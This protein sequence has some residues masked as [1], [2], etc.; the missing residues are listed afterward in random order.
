MNICLLVINYNGLFFLNKYLEDISKVCSSS[1]IDLIVSDDKSGD[2]SI[3]YLISNN[4]N[5]TI[6][7]SNNHGFASNVNNGIKY[8]RGI[9]EYDYFIIA[10]ND[11]ELREGLFEKVCELL[12]FLQSKD[13][14]LGIVGFDEIGLDKKKYFEKFDFNQYSLESTISVKD[15]PGFFFILSKELIDSIGYFDEDYFM[16]GEDNDYFTR[17]LKANFTIYNSLLPVMH[18]SESSST[19]YKTTSWYVYRNTFLYARKNLSFIQSIRLFLTFI[20]IIYNPFYEN[21]SPSALR[22]KRCGFFTNNYFLV[23]SIVW[24]ISFYFK[25]LFKIDK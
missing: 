4:I 14:F 13:K 24:N 11:I 21:N 2:K 23:K 3:Q 25:T 12:F 9:K 5:Y 16:Y 22:V 17:T 8:A 6:N 19:N 7:E 10:N 15:I 20:Y 1:T 18:Y